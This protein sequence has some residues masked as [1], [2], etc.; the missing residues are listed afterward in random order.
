MDSNLFI[1]R[2]KEL[3]KLN[4]LLSKKVASLVVVKG[5]R[6]IGKSRLIEEFARNKKYYIFSGLP[7]V[8]NTTA[9]SQLNEFARQLSAQTGL[10]EIIANDWSK[11]FLLLG[12]KIKQ[13]RIIVLLDEI[14]W[15]GSMDPDFLGKLKNAWDISFKQNP[16]LILILCGSVSYWIEKNIISSTGFFGRISLKITLEDLHLYECNQLFKHI[17]FNRSIHEKF[18]LLSVMGGIPRYIELVNPKYSALENIKQL[19]FEKD[20]IL[21][22][23]FHFIFHDLFGHRGTLYRSIVESLSLGPLEYMDIADSLKYTS[24]G[25]LSGYLEELIVSG[26]IK[27]DYTWSL[28]TGKDSS[29]LSKFRLS[30]NY[31]R[32]YL[33]YIAPELGQIQKGQFSDSSLVS[34]ANFS[35]IM[36]YQLENLVLN[37]R[38]A[39]INLLGL[40]P[41]EILSDNPFFQHKTTKQKG[42]Q[43]D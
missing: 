35:A 14:S 25:A 10:P 40:K 41:E 8:E 11:L 6:R 20:G 32:F 21:T 36:G 29:R 15:M 31:I 4:D 9:E 34:K 18:Q 38:S 13:G 17:G 22:D 27:R 1:G 24:S 7:P 19:C 43:I 2:K 16:E 23:E 12:E 3:A 5:R 42:C 37:N 33:K 30:D 39:I 28:K 26:F